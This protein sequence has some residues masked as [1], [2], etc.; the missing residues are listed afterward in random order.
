MRHAERPGAS[1]ASAHSRSSG[2]SDGNGISAGPFGGMRK[3]GIGRELGIEGLDAFR[4]PKHVHMDYKIEA[5]PYWYPYRW[6]HLKKE[7]EA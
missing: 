2:W 4:E 1:Q 7:P 5:K 3:S 6:S